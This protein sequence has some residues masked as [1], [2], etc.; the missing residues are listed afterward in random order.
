LSFNDKQSLLILG[1]VG[2]GHALQ[3]RLC[4]MGQ[5]SE[6]AVPVLVQFHAY[7]SCSVSRAVVL[8]IIFGFRH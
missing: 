7:F 1:F 6:H 3:Y 4:E 5:D 8:V 2:L